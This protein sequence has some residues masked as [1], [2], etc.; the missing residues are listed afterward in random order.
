MFDVVLPSS[1]EEIIAH[2]YRETNSQ[3]M[4]ARATRRMLSLY[5]C[6][7]IAITVPHQ[8]LLQDI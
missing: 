2:P 6:A 3:D 8:S 1:Q 5:P 4:V 7:R